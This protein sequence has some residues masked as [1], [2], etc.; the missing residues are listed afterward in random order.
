MAQQVR[1]DMGL[2]ICE[3]PAVFHI[4]DVIVKLRKERGWTIEEMAERADINK[5][6]LSTVERG[7]A[8]YRRE[9][10]EKI[11]KAL[12]VD[13]HKLY[14]MAGLVVGSAAARAHEVDADEFDVSGYTPNDIPV[15]AEGEAS[16]QGSLFWS[17]EGVL[18]S[19]VHDRIS[20]PRD[21][22]DPKAYGVRVRGDSMAPAYREGTLL[23]VSPNTPVKSG[24]ETYVQLLNGERLLKIAHR[25][26]GGWVLESM[27]P[28]YPPRFVK[29]EEVG[30]IHPV[31]WA[32]RKR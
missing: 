8:N 22:K 11:A 19:D 27:N 17:D 25:Q 26:D 18:H 4:G 20:R 15:I 6:T 23:V 16:P 3:T 9:T 5:G 10:I 12:D 7:E 28:A 1:L 29:H 2:A 14:A 13:V 32:R 24:D 31:M 30:A 21:V